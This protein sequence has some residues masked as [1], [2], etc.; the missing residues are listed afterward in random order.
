MSSRPSAASKTISFVRYGWNAALERYAKSTIRTH[1]HA[2]TGTCDITG[3][4]STKTAT[5]T[6][7]TFQDAGVAAGYRFVVDHARTYEVVSITSQ[8]ALTVKQ[9]AGRT[10]PAIASDLQY[11]VGPNTD[12]TCVQSAQRYGPLPYNSQGRAIECRFFQDDATADAF[13]DRLVQYYADTRSKPGFQTGYNAI[14]IQAG[15]TV[16]LNH[17]LLPPSRRPVKV[18][19]LSAEIDADGLSLALQDVTS[20]PGDDGYLIVDTGDDVEIVKKTATTSGTVW[21]VTRAQAD[22]DARAH[23]SGVSVYHLPDIYQVLQVQYIP[24][25]G[26]VGL[27]IETI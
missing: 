23:A 25:R 18:A 22:T 7:A 1:A 5:D 9:V 2:A 10:A 20:T 27:F 19:E 14:N 21:A 3:S 11:W 16:L 17:P 26:R 13:I 15:D 6:S 24:T 4:G 8:T 12:Y